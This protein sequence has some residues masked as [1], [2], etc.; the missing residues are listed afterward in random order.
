M[1]AAST[2]VAQRETV[3]FTGR[4][5]GVGFRYTVK[6]LAL[7][8]AVT[9][10]VRNMPDGRVEVV[11]EGAEHER[12]LLVQAIREKMQDYIRQVDRHTAAATGEFNNFAIRH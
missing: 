7:Q 5:Q 10:Y 12:E 11:M 3:L 1:S 4:V 8:H 9:G 6:N 2:Q